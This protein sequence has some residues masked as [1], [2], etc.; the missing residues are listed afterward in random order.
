MNLGFKVGDKVKFQIC[1]TTT[2]SVHVGE[3]T[4]I[5]HVEQTIIDCYNIGL[6][7]IKD[8]RD[9][10]Y[11]II[12]VCVYDGTFKNCRIKLSELTLIPD[13]SKINYKIEEEKEMAPTF[14]RN[15]ASNINMN[16]QIKSIKE[17]TKVEIV[18]IPQYKAAPKLEQKEYKI[19]T[20]EFYSGGKQEAIC[21]PGDSYDLTRGIEVCIM[22]QLFGG[23]KAYNDFLRNCIKDYEKDLA[24][25]KKQAED[26]EIKLRRKAKNDKRKAD[27]AAKKKEA[28]R[29]AQI[30]MLTEAYLNAMRIYESEFFDDVI[31][32]NVE[33]LDTEDDLK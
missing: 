24:E 2:L 23:T 29:Q 33:S 26:E 10:V 8:V 21:M 5:E 32:P 28:K 3:I 1:T 6:Y 14:N 4:Q 31:L 11:A 27:M 16:F 9:K 12:R 30:D 7:D 18:K 22:K 25:K 20:V 19:V 15:V 13:N 17:S